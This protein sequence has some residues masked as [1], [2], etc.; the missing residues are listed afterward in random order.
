MGYL[1]LSCF[2]FGDVENIIDQR[3]Q[4]LGTVA[5]HVQLFFLFVIQGSHPFAQE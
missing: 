3:K 4:V 1:Q 5:H 2:N